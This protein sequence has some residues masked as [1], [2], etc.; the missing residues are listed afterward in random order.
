MRNGACAERLAS[1]VQVAAE[2]D[3][4]TDQA[5]QCEEHCEHECMRDELVRRLCFLLEDVVDLGLGGVAIGCGRESERSGG[6][7]GDIEVEDVL[8]GGSSRAE[9]CEDDR[10]TGRLGRGEELEG[11]VLLGLQQWTLAECYSFV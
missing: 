4:E 6:V 3:P 1:V 10:G 9:R 11:K 2:A 7:A 8:V 5:G